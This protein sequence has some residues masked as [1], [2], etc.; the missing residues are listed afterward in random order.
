MDLSNNVRRPPLHDCNYKSKTL[1]TIGAQNLFSVPS[2]SS[3]SSASRPAACSRTATN[4]TRFSRPRRHA[5]SV[6]I[7]SGRIGPTQNRPGSNHCSLICMSYFQSSKNLCT[8][9]RGQGGSECSLEL[10][11]FDHLAEDLNNKFSKRRCAY[12]LCWHVSI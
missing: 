8:E 7:G 9:L 3:R 12:H 10:T 1:H 5:S 11:D 6:L 2:A 4:F